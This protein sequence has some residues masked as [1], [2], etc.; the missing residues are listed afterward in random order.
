MKSALLTPVLLAVILPTSLSAQ[1]PPAAAPAVGVVT[2]ATTSITTTTEINGR[3]ESIGRVGLMARVSAFLDAQLF[4]EGD[5]VK[6]GDVLFRLER[7]P[8]EAEVEARRAAVAQ[9]QAQLENADLTLGRVSALL[10]TPAGNK[11]SVDNARAAQLTASAQVRLA[12]AQLKQA[13]INL[14]Y[15]E[16]TSPIDGRIG[17]VSAT[18]GNVVGPSSGALATV[19]SQDPMYVT[20]P[21]SVRRL[22]ELYRDLDANGGLGSVR[23]RLRLPDGS[24]YGPAGKLEF[25]DTNVARDTDSIIMRGTIPNPVLPSGRRQLTNDELVRVILESGRQREMLAVPRAAILTDQQGDYVY[26]V[27]E[28]DIAQQRR[29]KLGQSTPQ[30]ATILEGLREGERVV[31]DGIQRVRPNTVVAPTPV[32]STAD[33]VPRSERRAVQ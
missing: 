3:V 8:Y 23:V 10:S 24:L 20:F 22:Q 26:V 1:T 6:K 12:E 19:V 32:T 2:V 17:R 14:D 7:P 27:G 33:A 31:V 30:T 15:T 11:S 13:L 16:I 21:M 4:V 25:V 18:V 29:V 5:E 28:K 9:A